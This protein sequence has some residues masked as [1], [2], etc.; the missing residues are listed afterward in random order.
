MK[1][2]LPPD[3]YEKIRND[4]YE[5]EVGSSPTN[6][7]QM[8]TFRGILEDILEIADKN[9]DAYHDLEGVSIPNLIRD[10]VHIQISISD[11]LNGD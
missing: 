2:Y 5:V 4:V 10:F 7:E 1:L 8:D 6:K 9:I 3:I 11:A